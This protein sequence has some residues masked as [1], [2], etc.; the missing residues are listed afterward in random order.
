MA[1]FP[2]PSFRVRN[3]P[4]YGDLILSPMDGF[5]DQPFRSICREMG[6]AM[7]YTEF[8]N[9]LDVLH[10]NPRLARKLAFKPEERPVVYQ[11][12]DN[13]P[14]NL[15]QAALR[16]R[17]RGPDILDVNLG[18]SARTVSGRG[19]GAG[20]LRDPRKIAGIFQ[21]LTQALDIPVTAKM[22]L[23]WDE[24]CLNYRLVAR[25]IEENGGALIAVH[26]RTRAQ[27][28]RGEADWDAIAEV[29]QEVS[30]PV[31]GN[32]D[33]RNV[34]DVDRLK[35]HTGC[36]AVMIGRGALGNPWIFRRMDRDQ[37]PVDEV[38][39]LALDHLSRMLVF[40][41]PRLGLVQFRK[42]LVRYLS[43][44]PLPTDLRT[45]LF[46]FENAAELESFLTEIPKELP[47]LRSVG[48]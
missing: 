38:R 22:R 11:I 20:L 16:L 8:I 6:S 42:Y 24:T 10:G 40:W 15:L 46:S 34:A 36:V 37:V 43:P 30:I 18:C 32:G 21:K 48:H 28:M 26:G 17:E 29:V 27:G 31:I 3:I 45:R 12:F 14:E 13:D 33:V 7:S 44:Y 47:E 9:A 2:P 23:G 41:G 39:R 25:V 4:V 35:A 1:S 5:S 19:A